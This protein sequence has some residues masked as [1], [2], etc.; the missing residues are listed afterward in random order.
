MVAPSYV[1]ALKT[2]FISSEPP[3]Y[4]SHKLDGEDQKGDREGKSKLGGGQR[5]GAKHTSTKINEDYLY[6][7]YHRHYSAERLVF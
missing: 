5:R 2:V 6:H 4:L 7:T 3:E 1:I